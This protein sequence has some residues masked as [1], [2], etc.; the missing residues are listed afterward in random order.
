MNHSML[1]QFEG[2]KILTPECWVCR[3]VEYIENVWEIVRPSECS[4]FGATTCARLY[5]RGCAVE[6]LTNDG[7]LVPRLRPRL[8]L[9]DRKR[10]LANLAFLTEPRN[11][12][13]G[14]AIPS[15]QRQRHR[16]LNYVQTQPNRS[17]C[18]V[19]QWTPKGAYLYNI[20]ETHELWHFRNPISHPNHI[21]T[22]KI[23]VLAWKALSD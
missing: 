16:F 14:N 18:H 4:T 15:D 9:E 19:N 11:E 1:N 21:R 8:I 3:A 20:I 13:I 5:D 2:L 6:D 17:R 22:S 23:L 12:K 10:A 7:C